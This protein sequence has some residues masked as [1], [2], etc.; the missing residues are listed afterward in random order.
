MIDVV[1]IKD[2]RIKIGLLCKIKRQAYSLTQE[3][4]AAAL[5]LSRYTIQKLETGKNATLDTVLKIANHFG[6][7]EQFYQSLKELE[8]VSKVKSFY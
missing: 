2:V 8:A 3:E 5:G 7:L 1:T 6:L 4:L